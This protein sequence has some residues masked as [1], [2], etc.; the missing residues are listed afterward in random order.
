MNRN[1]TKPVSAFVALVHR[2]LRLAWRRR[3]DAVAAILFFII[4]ASLFPLGAGTEPELLRRMAPGVIWVA[5]LLAS[6]LSLTRLFSDDHSDGSLEQLLLVPTPLPV[7]VLA[8]T[9]SHWVIS[10]VPLIVVTPVL[11]I[12]YHLAPETTLTLVLSLLLGTPLL[13][14]IGSVGSA[15]VL[16]ARGAA[17]LLALLIL[18]LYVPVLIFGSGA[19]RASLDGLA[20]S[21]HFSLLGALL[22]VALF[23]APWAAAAALRIAYD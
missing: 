17:I 21:G 14:L 7:L 3:S 20:I 19:V 22:L 16:G 12:Q 23:L 9:V 5:A 10:G 2:D 11:A 1:H 15:L 8:K 4:V 18:P 13:S 6:M